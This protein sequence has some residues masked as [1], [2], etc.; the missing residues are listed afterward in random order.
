MDMWRRCKARRPAFRPIFKL[1]IAPNEGH[2]R[3]PVWG[4]NTQAHEM[5]AANDA[6][7]EVVER[8]G[9]EVFDP[10]PLGLHAQYRWYDQNRKDMQHSDV[11]SDLLTQML[12]NQIC[13][14]GDSGFEYLDT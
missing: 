5:V 7:R 4:Y 8:A 10:F 9:F 12:I 6:A 14:G 11:L 3:L 13:D 2:C 1:A